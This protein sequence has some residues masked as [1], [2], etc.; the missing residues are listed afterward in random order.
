MMVAFPR[1]RGFKGE[2][3]VMGQQFQTYYNQVTFC[4]AEFKNKIS[5]LINVFLLLQAKNTKSW[6]VCFWNE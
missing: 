4:P 3:W 2:R 1:N 5:F 6:M